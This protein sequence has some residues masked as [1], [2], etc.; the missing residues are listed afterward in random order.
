MSKPLIPPITPEASA[1][2]RKLRWLHVFEGRKVLAEAELGKGLREGKCGIIR[3]R[4]TCE[5]P[6]I[7]IPST[8]IPTAMV[9]GYDSGKKG[10]WDAW[11]GEVIGSKF[12]VF[13]R[14]M[15]EVNGEFA[16]MAEST[17]EFDGANSLI[18]CGY[19]EVRRV[20]V[21]CDFGYDEECE[22]LYNEEGRTRV[23]SAAASLYFSEDEE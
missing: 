7:L 3:I 13:D 16:D 4:N 8:I 23:P 17:S 20:Y 12:S 1:K 5:T 9:E 15:G 21:P 2:A 11:H 22:K 18:R 6:P 10:K 14:G 19:D